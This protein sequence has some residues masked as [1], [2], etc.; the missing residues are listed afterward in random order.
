MTNMLIS[1]ALH[2]FLTAQSGDSARRFFRL[3]G[4]DE[5]VYCDLLAHFQTDGNQLAGQPLLARTTAPP[6]V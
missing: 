5:A 2:T 6:G 4:F 1:T 3:D